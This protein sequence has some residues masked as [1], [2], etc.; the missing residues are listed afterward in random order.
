MLRA[1]KNTIVVQKTRPFWSGKLLDLVTVS[2]C[3]YNDVQW[4]RENL[5]GIWQK[6]DLGQLKKVSLSMGRRWCRPLSS[7]TPLNEKFLFSKKRTRPRET[8][9]RR[10]HVHRF[11]C[12]WGGLLLPWAVQKRNMPRNKDN[13]FSITLQSAC[14]KTPPPRNL[15]EIGELLR[16]TWYVFRFP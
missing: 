15:L 2:K 13:A 4:K 16:D 9:P 6:N 14:E 7:Q 12:G 1:V 10:R 11:P 8:G 5:P 3:L